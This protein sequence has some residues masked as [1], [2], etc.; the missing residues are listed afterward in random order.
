MRVFLAGLLAVLSLQAQGH[1]NLYSFEKETAVGRE[2][3]KGLEKHFTLVSPDVVEELG[4]QLVST[5]PDLPFRI[6]FRVFE[7]A[8][9]QARQIPAQPAFPQNLESVGFL[10][11]LV[12]PGGFI[13][14]PS[15]MLQDLSREELA[16]GLAHALS[17]VALRHCTRMAT[18]SELIQR[19]AAPLPNQTPAM[20]EPVG[21]QKLA[22]AF[23]LEADAAAIPM[24]EKIGFSKRALRSYLAKLPPVK[25]VIFASSPSPEERLAT[26]N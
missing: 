19:A 26:I 20:Q 21:L 12:L 18:R 7:S 2:L 15:R 13:F 22:R 11:P 23:E 5:M 8:K 4:G 17:H 1:V 24:L 25:R 6:T 14:I 16:A 3:A 9:V 10:E